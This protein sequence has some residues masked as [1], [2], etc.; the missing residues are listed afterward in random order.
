[1][2]DDVRQAK[3]RGVNVSVSRKH[4]T[5]IGRFIKGDS[6]NEAKDKLERVIEKDQPVPYTKYDSDLAHRQGDMDQG[7]YPVSSAKEVLRILKSAEQNAINEGLAEDSLYIHEFYANQG[8][9]RPTPKRNR[10]QTPKSA[11]ITIKLRER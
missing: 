5:E 1:M 9:S 8:Q 11:H 2:A 3:A 7:R 10:G 6:V 4:C